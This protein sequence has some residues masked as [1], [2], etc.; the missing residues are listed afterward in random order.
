MQALTAELFGFAEKFR[1]F[2]QRTA[3]GERGTVNATR[4]SIDHKDVL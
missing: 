3:N 4:Q 2:L 1:C